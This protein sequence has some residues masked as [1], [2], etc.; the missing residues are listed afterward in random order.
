MTTGYTEVAV[1][2]D[3]HLLI[4]YDRVPN[5]WV[6]IPADSKETNSVWVVR[7]A[8]TPARPAPDGA[9]IEKP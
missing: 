1:V 3:T 4:I 6:A 5:G 8:M 2:D 7:V 9:I